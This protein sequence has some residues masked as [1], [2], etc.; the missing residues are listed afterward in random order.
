MLQGTVKQ[1]EQGTSD[2]E[3]TKEK[4]A[5]VEQELEDARE[6]QRLIVEYPDLNGPVNKDIV[7]K[8]AR[9]TLTHV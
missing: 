6:R 9:N 4:L 2:I 1:L 5:R 7:G 3:K 8:S